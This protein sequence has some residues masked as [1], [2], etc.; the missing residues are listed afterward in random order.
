MP[1]VCG[2]CSAL[3]FLEVCCFFFLSGSF[4]CPHITRWVGEEE[5][6]ESGTLH[7]P[8]LPLRSLHE[9]AGAPQFRTSRNLGLAKP[10]GGTPRRFGSWKNGFLQLPTV[11]PRCFSFVADMG[12]VT[13]GVHSPSFLMK[14]QLIGDLAT[15]PSNGSTC[16]LAKRLS[17]VVHRLCSDR[18]ETR[19]YTKQ[20]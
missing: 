13:R 3:G 19:P 20:R 15:N 6:K 1:G 5:T 7:K 17:S 4:C 9:N 14:S 18:S 16:S 8:Q 10:L 11:D 12:A 2:H